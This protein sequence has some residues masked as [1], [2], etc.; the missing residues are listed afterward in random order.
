L[1]TYLAGNYMGGNEINMN[2]NHL[3]FL[4]NQI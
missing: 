2:Y 1:R 3:F 4:N